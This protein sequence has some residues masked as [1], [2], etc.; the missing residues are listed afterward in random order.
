MSTYP[1][2][3]IEYIQPTI[4]NYIT[5]I[6]LPAGIVGGV[7]LI[8]YFLIIRSMGIHMQTNL[9][10]VNFILIIPVVIY[11]LNKYVDY[12]HAKTYLKAFVVSW[13]SSLIASLSLG[14]FMVVY[15]F[16]DAEFMNF[17][18][19][20]AYPELQLTQLG[21]FALIMFEGLIGGVI[22]SFV[23]LQFFKDRIRKV[24]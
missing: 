9:R 6:S 8:I 20:Q 21:I 22:I 17:L 7:L 23:T 14:I 13:A 18:Y 10:W 3:S 5:K 11:S 1:D 15:L 24:A 2:K 12:A 16:A 4:S 19:E